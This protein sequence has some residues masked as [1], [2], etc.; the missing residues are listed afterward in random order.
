ML[1]TQLP[2]LLWISLFAPYDGVPHASGKIQNFYLKSLKNSNTFDIRMI[3]FGEEEEVNKIDLDKWDIPYDLIIYQRKGIIAYILKWIDRLSKICIYNRYAGLTSRF[4]YRGINK[5]LKRLKTEDYKP[6][7][8]VLD[9]TEILFLMKDVKKI[10]PDVKIVSIEEDV[11]FLGYERKVNHANS[12]MKKN[13][14]AAKGKQIKKTELKHLRDSDLCIT[15]NYKDQ[16][17]IEDNIRATNIWTWTPYFQSMIHLRRK[18]PNKNLLFYGAMFRPEN[19]KSALWFIENVFALIE[20][21][22]VK[23]IIVGNKPPQ[24]IL[25]YQS[26]RIQVL[27]FMEDIS[28]VFDKSLCLVAPLVLGA[29]VKIKVLEGMSSG[30]PVLTNEIGIEGISARDGVEYFH[31]VEPEDYL[32]VIQQLLEQKIDYK[33]VEVKAKAFIKRNYNFDADANIFKNKL[34]SLQK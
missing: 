29:G 23:F 17:L 30:I 22:E 5:K 33:D 7:I 27:G 32:N 21:K 14:F 10:F 24:D 19:W 20:D 6:D 34:S 28:V 12:F 15:N 18:T 4:I 26:E 31:C 25:K 16:T 8:V 9:W 2:K 1:N 11:T 13:F 3:T